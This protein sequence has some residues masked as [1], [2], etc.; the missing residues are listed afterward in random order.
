M[1]D[2]DKDPLG[3]A[4]QKTTFKTVLNT[5]IIIIVPRNVALAHTIVIQPNFQLTMLD[6][7]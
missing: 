6:R 3:L 4:I 1:T 2:K 5:T 7:V